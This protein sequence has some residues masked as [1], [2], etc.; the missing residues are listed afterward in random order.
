MRPWA[1]T[2]TGRLSLS[3]KIR[4]NRLS[5]SEIFVAA[6]FHV[7]M[8][9]DEKCPC[10]APPLDDQTGG[11]PTESFLMDM[12]PT[13][14]YRDESEDRS[15]ATQSSLYAPSPFYSFS[16][17]LHYQADGISGWQDGLGAQ[18]L[19]FGFR[20]SEAAFQDPSSRNWQSNFAWTV[21]FINLELPSVCL[22]TR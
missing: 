1:F 22:Q 4:K 2:H 21:P 20:P 7:L 16:N 12:E 10:S 3:S 14:G 11:P 9:R 6:L 8:N 17:S 13:L 5:S 19:D 15:Y 18:H